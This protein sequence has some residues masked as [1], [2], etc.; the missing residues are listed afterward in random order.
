MIEGPPN[1]RRTIGGDQP[2]LLSN[3][4]PRD[5]D[6]VIRLFT[7]PEVRRY[8]GGPLTRADAESRMEQLL[9]DASTGR[10]WAIR[11][12]PDEGSEA[13]GLVWL[14]QHRNGIDLEVS[15][16]LLPEWQGRG[17]AFKA[18]R[19]ALA[20]AFE[21]LS[22]ERV[23]AETQSANARSIALLNRL[24]MTLEGHLWRFGAEQACFTMDPPASPTKQPRLA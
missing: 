10:V 24:G 4:L 2:R 11:R 17:F 20:F 21:S 3:L 9:S 19:E 1:G 18:C 7:D 13:I 14:E 6:P 15:F 23:V 16:V 22:A 5:A 12:D 8:L